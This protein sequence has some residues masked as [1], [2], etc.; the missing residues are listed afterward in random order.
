MHA[1]LL[2]AVL[3][4]EPEAESRPVVDGGAAPGEV[5]GEG[6][7]SGGAAGEGESSDA[8]PGEGEGEG[9]AAPHRL[10][11]RLQGLEPCPVNP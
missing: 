10:T 11:N 8:E 5:T 7:S 9:E 4:P 2:I 3:A 6:E 1:L